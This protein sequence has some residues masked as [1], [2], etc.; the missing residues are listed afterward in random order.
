M[1]ELEVEL[2][3]GVA[4]SF[5]LYHRNLLSLSCIIIVKSFCHD[6]NETNSEATSPSTIPCAYHILWLKFLNLLTQLF[7][8]Q[9]L[10]IF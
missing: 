2:E 8:F 3:S 4:M 1:K 9:C 7:H 6:R 10:L 5:P